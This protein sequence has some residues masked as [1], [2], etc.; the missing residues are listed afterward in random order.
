M[1]LVPRSQWG[2]RAYRTPNGATPYSRARRGVKLHYLGTPYT[3]RPHDTCD[4]YVRQIQ[5]QHM[6]GNG[7][8]DIGYSF[9]VCTHGY[10]YEGRGLTRRNSANGNTTLNDQD[11]AV[12]LMVGSSGLTK[13]T[14]AQ[15]HGARDAIDYCRKEG[16]AGS[17]LGG[18]RDGYA[19]ACPGD[20]VYAWVKKGAPR[21]SSGGSTGQNP[22]PGDT[23][24]VKSGDTLSSIG[25]ALDVPWLDIARSNGIRSPY[26][27]TPGQKLTIPKV[28]NPPAPA[29]PATPTLPESHMKLS[30]AVILGDWVKKEWPTDKGLADGKI[31]VNAALGSGYAHAR[32]A[33][34]NTDEIL[35]QL[36]ALRTE[37]AQLRA[38]VQKES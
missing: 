24:T 38:A 34:E 13:P 33:R 6:D 2:A 32:K 21:P 8:S 23:Y 7:W 10:V 9:V 12:L 3:D 18:H 28:S 26:R 5:A 11:Y 36:E 25:Q 15:L 27:I 19:T 35:R 22:A 17:W 30:D 29:K 37:V 31:A 20:A 1:K 4:D 14:D 16:P